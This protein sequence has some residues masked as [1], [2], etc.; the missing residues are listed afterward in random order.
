[1]L[2]TS[3]VYVKLT[4][5][6]YVKLTSSVYVKLTSSVNVKH[7]IGTIKMSAPAKEGN[8]KYSAKE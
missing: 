4:S 1:M 6:V 2:N 5:S 8:L 3:S 7:V